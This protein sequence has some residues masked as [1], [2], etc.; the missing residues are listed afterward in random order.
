MPEF[1]KWFS[2]N[3]EHL[4]YDYNLSEKSVVMDLG[5]YEGEFSKQIH[6]KYNCTIYGFEPVKVFFT[7]TNKNLSLFNKIHLFNYGIGDKSRLETICINTDKS[8]IY[9]KIGTKETIQIKSI[10]EVMEEI[11]ITDVDLIKINVEGAE[12]EILDAILNYGLINKFK[13]IQIQFH[14]F[15]PNAEYRRNSIRQR[16][17]KTHDVTYCYEFV[18]ENHRI[19]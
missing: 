10:K 13:N 17:H 12:Y 15:F 1:D 4:R 18:W 6:N 11:K 2:E 16:L 8:S 5:V 9:S 7:E 14:D 19:K 3:A